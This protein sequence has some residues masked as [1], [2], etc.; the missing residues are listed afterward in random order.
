MYY[1]AAEKER[2]SIAHLSSKD[3]V[4]A[5]AKRERTE[6][7]Q[8]QAAAAAEAQTAQYGQ[9]LTSRYG[10]KSDWYDPK[11]PNFQKPDSW[12]WH[13][14]QKVSFGHLYFLPSSPPSLPPT[15]PAFLCVS[16]PL[17]FLL[18]LILLP[19]L[20]PS[21]P[22]LP[23]HH[24][25]KQK[26]MGGKKSATHDGSKYCPPK[27]E[28]VYKTN[29]IEGRDWFGSMTAVVDYLKACAR[30]KEF[31]PSL[32][33]FQQQ[34][35]AQLTGG[36][37]GAGAGGGGVG[38]E[39][40]TNGGGGGGGRRAGGKEG[41]SVFILAK[42]ADVAALQ[43]FWESDKELVNA[44]YTGGEEEE[45]EE[46]EALLGCTP[47][48]FAARAGQVECMRWLL[49]KG[50]N[51]K[52][53]DPKGCSV[54]HHAAATDQA[55]VITSLLAAVAG[56]ALSPGAVDKTEMGFTPLHVAVHYNNLRAL[57]VLLRSPEVISKV[58]SI[59]P[60]LPPS[61]PPSLFSFLDVHVDVYYNNLRALVALL[62]SPEVISK[63]RHE[64]RE[65]G[66]V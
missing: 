43:I 32:S 18:L 39:T 66:C 56:T 9:A 23:Q 22:S 17:T 4:I 44:V 26:K 47:L 41:M 19:S 28:G 50:A 30:R 48:F 59:L 20:P 37:A 24:G 27:G 31:F 2:V 64:G 65:G 11:L 57:E 3:Y 33:D 61:L 6:A 53:L 55:E 63:T 46:E 8:L 49:G 15:L 45:E 54:Y 58:W 38:G 42:Q 36:K 34:H 10:K 12:N 60:S 25:W 62:R 52:H 14:L 7:Y 21:L 16:I 40:K 1:T 5:K 51:V 13:M 35:F 29:G